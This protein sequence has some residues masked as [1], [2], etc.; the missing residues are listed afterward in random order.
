MSRGLTR[1]DATE[2]IIMSFFQELIDLAPDHVKN[3]LTKEIHHH[4]HTVQI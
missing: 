1:A 3:E 2:L 4:I